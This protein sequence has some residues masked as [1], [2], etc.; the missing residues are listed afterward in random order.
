M[1]FLNSS[2]N[3]L[4][5]YSL[6]LATLLNIC[7]N[8]SIIL[9]SCSTFFNSITFIVLLSLLLN[10]FFRS[11]RNSSTIMNSKLL[12]S[13]SSKTFFFQIS[14]DSPYTYDNTHWICSFTITFLIFILIYN[15]HAIKKSKTLLAFLL[16]V[17]DLAT[18]IF[19]SILGLEAAISTS[20]S[21]SLV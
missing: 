9:F 16:N 15:L 4:L 11:M 17:S 3:S 21:S 6:S 2:I 13:K 12:F 19:D 18:S 8:F 1:F 20:S 10:S 5:S 7:T 14:T